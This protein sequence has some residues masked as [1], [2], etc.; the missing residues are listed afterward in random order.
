M[1][2][3][4]RILILEDRKEDAKLIERE[5]RKG[6][7]CVELQVVQTEEAF[8][9]AMEGFRPDLILADYRLPSFDGMTALSMSRKNCP[10]IPFIFVSGTI[11]EDRAIETL[12]IGATDYVLKN[13]L[14][15]LV[16]VVKR[17]LLEAEVQ[18]AE[19]KAAHA[20]EQSRESFRATFDLAAVGVANVAPDGGWLRVNR[21][22][23]EILGY[24]REELLQ[25][26]FHDVTHPDDLEITL[27]SNSRLLSG[28]INNYSMEKR[29]IRKDGRVIWG[30]LA[31]ALSRDNDGRPQFFV[32]VIEDVTMRRQAEEQVR[33]AQKMEALGTLAGGIAHDFNNILGIIMGYTEMARW[34]LVEGSTARNNLDEVFNAGNR[35]KELV[36]QILAFSRRTGQEKLPMQLG[37]IIKEAMKILRPSLPSTIEIRT[38]VSGEATVMADPTQMHQVL[39][40]LCTNASHAM[41]EQGGLL[42]VTLADVSL[43]GDS[44]PFHGDMKPGIYAELT[45]KDTGCGMDPSIMDSIFDPFFTTKTHGEGTGLGLSVVHGIVKSHE[46]RIDV[47]SQPG[48]GTRFT[49]LIPALE[50]DLAPQKSVIQNAL[51]HGNERVLVVDDEPMLGLA[52]ERMLKSLG[53]DVVSL[54]SGMEALDLLHQQPIEKPFDLVVTDMTMPRIT[55]AD[56]AQEVSRLQPRLPVILMTGF[57]KNMDV[58]KARSLG[59]QGFLM[60][61]VTLGQLAQTVRSALDC[62]RE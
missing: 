4:L 31:V 56:L 51:P 14:S 55:G 10:E 6:G 17:A 41:Q 1:D 15:R 23:C 48:K 40:N 54:T 62:P 7:L 57:S 33:Q 50:S 26:R 32:S 5:L 12:R 21:K 13:R 8:V 19:R 24:S 38:H 59:F 9:E 16:P 35:A 47:E 39:M 18:A 30:N 43:D 27:A 34:E 3:Q 46:G 44:I 45:V 29:Y 60:K 53:Y 28:E 49:V 61:P 20:L 58:E 2:Q 52:V 42:E 25:L 11:G 37:S 22:L 36:K